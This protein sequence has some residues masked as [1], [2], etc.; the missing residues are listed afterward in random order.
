MR[1]RKIFNSSEWLIKLFKLDISKT[2]AN[3][4]GIVLIQIDGLSKREFER[5]LSRN[6]LPFLGKLIRHQHY[7]LHQMYSGLPAST[8]AFQAELFYGIK[9]AVPAFGFKDHQSGKIVRMYEPSICKEI[10]KSLSETGNKALFKS[11]S[12]YAD[13]YTGGAEEA[14]FCPAALGWGHSL[15]LKNPLI[16]L[17]LLFT[18]IYAIFS[19]PFLLVIEFVLAIVDYFRGVIAG[20]DFIKELKFIPSRI[21]ISILL[22]ELTVMGVKMDISRGLPII[23]LNFLGFDEQAHRR[24]PRSWF[25]HWTLKGIDHA[26]HRIWK[27][28][29]RLTRR[30]YDVWIY[31]DHGQDSVTS[32]QKTTGKTLEQVVSSVMKKF[33]HS[34]AG[35]HANNET[36]TKTQTH[37]VKFLG[38]A[39]IQKL[40]SVLTDN[41]FHD[42]DNTQHQ[43]VAMGS[44]GFIY[45]ACALSLKQQGLIARELTRN[46]KIPLCIVNRENG[47]LSA[48]TEQGE[49]NLPDQITEII[50]KDHPFVNDIA[51][52][53]K[54][55]CQH[56][57]AGSIILFGWCKGKSPISFAEENG[58][59]AGCSPDETNAFALLPIDV[60]LT[61]TQYNYLRATDLR[62]ALISRLTNVDNVYRNLRKSSTDKKKHELRVM[63]Y[64]VHSCIGM[65]GNI[66]PERIARVINQ[67]A[68][69]V[70]LLQELDVGRN[71]T[72]G[73]DQAQL[74]ADILAM[75]C[76]FHPAMHY[77][78]EKYGNAILTHLPMKIV[79][80]GILPRLKHKSSSEYRGALWVTIK[81]DDKEVQFINTHLGLKRRE[82]MKQVEML[83]GTK[84]LANGLCREPVI[85]GGDFNALPSSKVCKKLNDYLR[86]AQSTMKDHI[87]VGTF[88]RKFPKVCIDHIYLSANIDV[89]NIQVPRTK[90]VQMASDHLPLVVDLSI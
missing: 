77:A 86:D 80:K 62:R 33:S 23:H 17:I 78:E 57:D 8:P 22:R 42:T 1:V 75:D 61:K 11:G 65:D 52:D 7:H 79:K 55:L 20:H 28:V 37:R 76:H 12:V 34:S 21:A 13:I 72:D 48:W 38:G 32:F 88:Y 9:T 64:N 24:G 90:I 46:E 66:S 6:E 36:K 3:K 10:E 40:F 31:S 56:P 54:A 74:I 58:A 39:K 70:I 41:S 4:P 43:V 85:L 60:P 87:P 18:N 71:R 50:G 67:Y 25:A 30:D 44:V 19:I 59:H 51:Q 68:P 81:V 16:L 45:P 84:W 73:V 69:D 5:A 14:H 53:I 89:L 63:T 83:L 47:D 82:R 2:S 15:R 49:F 29:H 35:V 26:I 27:A